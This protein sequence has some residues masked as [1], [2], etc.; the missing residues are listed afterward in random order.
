MTTVYATLV[1]PS[2][3][4]FDP[5]HGLPV[6]LKDLSAA[7]DST[8]QQAP[9][10]N[11]ATQ[12]GVLIVISAA[13]LTGGVGSGPANVLV[14]SFNTRTGDVLLTRADVIATG[15]TASDIGAGTG[16]GGAVSSVQGRTGDVVLTKSDITGTGL[17]AADL[18]AVPQTTTV[19][20]HSLSGN[21][22]LV[23]GDVGLGNVDN[24]ADANKS[25]L[26]ATKLTT[27]RT[28]N[29]ASFDGSINITIPPSG[30]PSFACVVVWDGTGSQPA[31]PV[32]AAGQPVF[33]LTPAANQPATGGT[34]GGGGNAVAN[35]DIWLR[36]G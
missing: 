11:A 4:R 28:I 17:V 23:K 26:S 31:R 1:D 27:A 29:G 34:V 33:Y 3:T 12:A 9:L 32:T 19:G 8:T 13:P 35:L 7:I 24:T 14:T 36:L 22:T 25:V 16:G 21:V 5:G 20:G 2:I 15:L 10:I 30:F 18:N 6:L